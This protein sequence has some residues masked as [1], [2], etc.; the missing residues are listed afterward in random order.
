MW[1][2]NK[3]TKIHI[4]GIWEVKDWKSQGKYSKKYEGKLP[5]LDESFKHHKRSMNP[6]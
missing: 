3:Y 2:I 6:K 1:D 5:K 4:M